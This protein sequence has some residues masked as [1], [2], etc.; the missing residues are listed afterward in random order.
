MVPREEIILWF[1]A[2]QA[3]GFDP[4]SKVPGYFNGVPQKFLLTKEHSREILVSACHDNVRGFYRNYGILETYSY[5]ESYLI[6][7]ME[8]EG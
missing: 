8:E 7:K 6:F 3:P 2:G 1:H 5:L 4:A